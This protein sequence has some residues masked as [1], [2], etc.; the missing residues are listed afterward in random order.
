MLQ[1]RFDVPEPVVL[2]S[3]KVLVVGGAGINE[4]YDPA[5]KTFTAAGGK[6]ERTRWFQSATLLS[7]GKVLVTGGSD[8]KKRSTAQAWIYTP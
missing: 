8:E 4:I 5:T 2:M 1:P 7:D 3:G 6:A